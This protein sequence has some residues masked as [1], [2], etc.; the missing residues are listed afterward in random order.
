VTLRRLLGDEPQWDPRDV[1]RVQRELLTRLD[2]WS[3]WVVRL[4]DT[5]SAQLAVVGTTGAF[6]I[7]VNGLEGY[8]E[9]EGERLSVGGQRVRGF[10]EVRTAARRIEGRLAAA[11]TFTDVVPLLCLSRAVAG[12]PRTARDVRVVRLED[13]AGE[14]GGRARA[15]HPNRAKRGAVSLGG[16]VTSGGGATSEETSE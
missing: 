16:V 4:P 7:A 6:A 14:I 8:L 11:A 2:P 13:L 3:Y 9:A 12:G 1:D 10:R 15:L 5:E